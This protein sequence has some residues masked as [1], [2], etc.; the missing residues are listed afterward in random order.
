VRW[1]RWVRLVSLGLR[2]RLAV[3]GWGQVEEKEE[4]A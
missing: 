1:V 2:D 4:D 3:Q